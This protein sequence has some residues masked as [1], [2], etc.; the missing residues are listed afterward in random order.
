MVNLGHARQSWPYLFLVWFE[1]YSLTVHWSLVASWSHYSLSSCS[2]CTQVP[3]FSFREKKN[4]RAWVGFK[5][6]HSHLRCDALPIELPSPWEQAGGKEGY[7][8]ASSWC[9]LHQKITFSY[10]TPL[11]VTMLSL[12]I[13]VQVLQEWIIDEL[14]LMASA[15]S[16]ELQWQHRHCQGVP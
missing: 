10:G 2:T 6:T 8:S 9:P 15:S 7:T 4:L 14:G 3:R 16:R 5:P 1:L 11:A 12:G 13:C